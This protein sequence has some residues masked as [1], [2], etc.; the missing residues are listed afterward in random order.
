MTP[1]DRN[2]EAKRDAL[3]DPVA[4]AERLAVLPWL[5]ERLDE[6][7]DPWDEDGGERIPP[8][9]DG[10]TR[11]HPAWLA[12]SA[13]ASLAQLRADWTGTLR[14]PEGFRRSAAGN[15]VEKLAVLPEAPDSTSG[16]SLLAAA[17][18]Q[19]PREVTPDRERRRIVP[20][21]L[22]SMAHIDGRERL[23]ALDVGTI[24]GGDA[25]G[26][27]PG[28]EPEKTA[29]VPA[30]PLQVWDG[31][32]AG[33]PGGGVPLSQGLWFE[34]VTAVPRSE[35]GRGIVRLPLTLRD[36]VA[37]AGWKHYRPSRHIPQL[38]RALLE[39][40]SF[41][42]GWER[43]DWKLVAP[44]ALPK[45]DAKLDDVLPVHVY[46][47]DGCERGPLID[48]QPL[49][50][51]RPSDAP[52][53]RAWARLAYLWNQYG[54]RKGRRIYATRPEVLRSA[55]GHPLDAGVEV[56]VQ[57]GKPAHWSH[58]RCVRTGNRERN[59]EADRIPVLPPADLVRLC[60]D[61]E[62]TTGTA[63]RHRL[64]LARR[65][66]DSMAAAG[67]IVIEKGATDRKGRRGWRVLEP[68][69]DTPD[70]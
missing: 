16:L 43:R 27:L 41:W 29:L 57:H 21:I 62:V 46:M 15:A 39:V 13:A 70:A 14:N 23:P 6:W 33:N 28:L 12:S 38:R 4:M 26:F 67:R 37:F 1:T 22:S 19:L 44:Q 11:A 45:L 30:L 56:I 64:R 24:G 5:T 47:P 36:L 25:Q 48:R 18:E 3:A 10:G 31:V 68:F 59:P 54:T 7:P 35:R 2:A 49:R 40:D 50:L 8:T 52:A 69:P 51:Y 34:A 17:V 63:Y 58:P 65:T 55:E 61:G 32:K 60:F 53:F 9:V 66:L 42:V 20:G